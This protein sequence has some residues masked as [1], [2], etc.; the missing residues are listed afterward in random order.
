MKEKG[1]LQESCQKK[2]NYKQKHIIELEAVLEDMYS[3]CAHTLT[4]E[5][6]CCT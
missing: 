5:L 6:R 3:I 2:E 4:D 1:K